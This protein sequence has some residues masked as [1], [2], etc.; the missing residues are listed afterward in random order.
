MWLTVV[1][2]LITGLGGGVIG[3]VIGDR[4]Q[5]LIARQARRDLAERALWTYH[6][7][8][9]DWSSAMEADAIHGDP[10]FTSA[11]QKT[12]NRARNKAYPYRSYLAADKQKLVTRNW[13]PEWTDRGGAMGVSEEFLTWAEEL[14]AELDRLFGKEE[15]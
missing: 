10:P 11:D 15:R 8:L 6:R 7:V 9:L 3:A 13:L 4:R 5:R 14:A 12:L 1:L 2:S